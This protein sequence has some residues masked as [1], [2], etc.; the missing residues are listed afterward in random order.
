M[1][2]LLLVGLALSGCCVGEIA[3]GCP[4]A[5]RGVVADSVVAAGTVEVFAAPSLGMTV[6]PQAVLVAPSY[7]LAPFVS[8][9]ATVVH[10]AA[11]SVRPLGVLR[12]R[13]GSVRA[14]S[15]VTVR[16]RVR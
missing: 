5:S 14:S 11:V 4:L 6:V 8:V 12:S 15:R 7:V 1:S 3:R 2:R 16:M 10:P 9:G 13:R